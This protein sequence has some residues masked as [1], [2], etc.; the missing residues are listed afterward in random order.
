MNR[1]LVTVF[2]Y[3]LTPKPQVFA[4]PDGDSSGARAKKRQPISRIRKAASSST[5]PRPVSD[6]KSRAKTPII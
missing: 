5:S 2:E 3:F 1:Q 6:T 4:I